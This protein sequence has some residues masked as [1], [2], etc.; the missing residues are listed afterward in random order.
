[1]SKKP[2]IDFNA[3]PPEHRGIDERLHNWGRWCN[4]GRALSGMSPMF[5]MV[6]PPPKQRVDVWE[7]EGRVDGLDA[8]AIAKGVAELPQPHRTALNWLYVRPCAP[9]R[10]CQAIGTS[11]QGLG[12]L[13]HDGRQMLINKKV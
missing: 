8:T 1:M 13:L 9:K 3:V 12:Q 7:S 2:Y 6:P 11:M 4:G 5:R 10:A